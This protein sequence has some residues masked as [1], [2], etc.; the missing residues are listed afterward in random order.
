[1][2]ILD[3]IDLS[4]LA[5]K[6]ILDQVDLNNL[7][8]P[9]E[10]RPARPDASGASNLIKL[11]P[12]K[13]EKAEKGLP[14]P[15]T[16]K[17]PMNRLGFG[18]IP[19]FTDF[20]N[21]MSFSAAEG[22]TG[23]A[24]TF[25]RHQAPASGY[26]AEA[27][28][29]SARK[30]RI[31]KT[32][33]DVSPVSGY[34]G[35]D[36][37]LLRQPGVNEEYG[38]EKA[39]E[40]KK[41]LND[42]A[43]ESLKIAQEYQAQGAKYSE[44]FI[45][46]LDEIDWTSP[47]DMVQY[48]GYAAGQAAVQIPLN[49]AT[50]GAA[51][52]IQEIGEIYLS[53]VE[54]IATEMSKKLGREVTMEEIIQNGLDKPGVA[55]AYGVL[56]GSLE[57][58]GAGKVINKIQKSALASDLRKRAL[59][60]LVTGAWEGGTEGA[61][62]LIEQ[63]GTQAASGGSP[64]DTKINWKDIVESSSQGTI[65]AGAP[66]IISHAIAQ[67][68]QGGA[69]AADTAESKTKPPAAPPQPSSP[70][71]EPKVVKE[72]VKP[73][74]TLKEKMSIVKKTE[75]AEKVGP[76]LT[77]DEAKV[78]ES[79]LEKRYQDNVPK[80]EKILT[81]TGKEK[82]KA[83][84][85]QASD[86]STQL[87]RETL[88]TKTGNVYTFNKKTGKLESRPGMTKKILEDTE[89]TGGA[90][91]ALDG[92]SPKTGFM[93]GR[94]P[95]KSKSIK[96]KL[97]AFQIEKF[98]ADNKELLVKKN[99]YVGVWFDGKKT[100]L[101]ISVNETNEAKATGMGKQFGQKA[102]Y[103]V[104][105]G[106]D[107]QTG[108]TGK[109]EKVALE[110]YSDADLSET[111]PAFHGTGFA[112]AEMKRKK[113]DPKNFVDRTYFYFNK[114]KPEQR[115]EGKK[116]FRTGK[117][118]KGDLY[119]IN[120]DFEGFK[121]RAKE[122]G[123]VGNDVLTM[124]EKWI[125]EA[126]YKGYYNTEQG[127][128]MGNAVAMFDKQSVA[129]D[130]SIRSKL[131]DAA[132]RAQKRIDERNKRT[133]ILVDPSNIADYAI[134][135]A[136]YI[137][138]GADTFAKWSNSMLDRY[139][140]EIK[141]YLRDIYPKALKAFKDKHK[142]LVIPNIKKAIAL[143]HA[144]ESGM[145]WYDATHDELVRIFGEDAEVFAKIVAA[146][147][148]NATPKA[149]VTKAIK[150]YSN[151]KMG[152]PIQETM[153]AIRDN[154]QR[155]RDGEE[156][157]GPKIRPFADA[158]M[159]DENAVVIDSWMW[160]IFGKGM[161]EDGKG[162]YKIK[163]AIDP[164][165]GKEAPVGAAGTD[166]QRQFII[167][168]IN[169]VSKRLKVTPR[170]VQAALW[171]GFKIKHNSVFGTEG[172]IESYLQD[173]FPKINGIR[174]HDQKTFAKAAELF[175]K[176]KEE[177]DY[178]VKLYTAVAK[179]WA[180]TTG[181]TVDDWFRTRIHSVTQDENI[182]TD[183]LMQQAA[184]AFYSKAARVI[185]EKMGS[186]MEAPS[187]IN[188]LLRY[189]VTKEEMEWSGLDQLTGTITKEQA[190]E[191]IETD[192]VRIEETTLYGEVTIAQAFKEL[193]KEDIVKLRKHIQNEIFGDLNLWSKEFA[194]SAEPLNDTADEDLYNNY[195]TFTR[196][197]IQQQELYL[198]DRAEYSNY[199]EK[200]P[201]EK[202][203]ELLLTLPSRDTRKTLEEQQKRAQIAVIDEK[204][205]ELEAAGYSIPW[206]AVQA[207]Q[208]VIL[209]DKRKDLQFDL[210]HLFDDEKSYQT[211]H[212]PQ[213]RPKNLLAHVRFN[214][215]TINGERTL[216][217]EEI[218]SDWHQQG[219]DE[220][221]DQSDKK[222]KEIELLT[223]YYKTQIKYDGDYDV[224]VNPDQRT[225]NYK[226]FYTGPNGY[227]AAFGKTKEDAL[228]NLA[229]H[230]AKR[231]VT[232]KFKDRETG[233]PDAPFKTS[234]QKL[235]LSRMMRWAAENGY[236]QIAWTTGKQQA[237]RYSLR[238]QVDHIK[239]SV[240]QIPIGRGNMAVRHLIN[241]KTKDGRDIQMRVTADGIVE[242]GPNEF[243]G[244]HIKNVVGKEIAKEIMSTGS[245]GQLTPEENEQYKAL[246]A[247]EKQLRSEWEKVRDL[248]LKPGPSDAKRKAFAITDK[249]Q[250]NEDA[251][252]RLVGIT[253]T[254][255]EEGLEIGGQG[256]LY[257]YDEQLVNI[258]DKL[259]KKYGTKS[260]MGTLTYNDEPI[261]TMKM[262][263]EMR[264]DL[265]IDGVPLF[266]DAQGAVR[267]TADGRAIIHAFEGKS[268]VSTA[269]HELAHI[270][271]KE[272]TREESDTILASIDKRVKDNRSW[273]KIREEH[274]ARAFE[275]YLRTGNAPNPEL[276]T[277]FE[278]FKAWLSDIY[279]VVAGSAI[280]VKMTKELKAYFDKVLNVESAVPGKTEMGGN[281]NTYEE[282]PSVDSQAFKKWFGDSKV[283]DENGAP[284]VVY[285]GTL[286]EPFNVF[287][288]KDSGTKLGSLG[289]YFTTDTSV[290]DFY[291]GASD[292]LFDDIEGGSVYPVYLSIKKPLTIT[293]KEY[294]NVVIGDDKNRNNF[295][296]NI[297]SR[298]EKGNYDGIKIEGDYEATSLT[299]LDYDQ[300]VALEPTQIKS[301]TGNRGTYDS[302]NPN[303]L[304]QK[305]YDDATTPEKLS[306][307]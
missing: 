70:K 126:G 137:S 127:A 247:E 178:I 160:R 151:Y 87:M 272:M 179:T 150:E 152:R 228:D 161:E 141:P 146:T 18:G 165:T 121:D 120:N 154:L 90:S 95:E 293:A 173:A 7:D 307:T 305:V 216:F 249:I 278:K 248:A 280:D 214:E 183:A 175:T 102:I 105:T 168:Y 232:A 21:N 174:V 266:Q 235:A 304:F 300:Y 22:F 78:L 135:G 191:K 253:K 176:D 44:G 181:N 114:T 269:I 234:W 167:E 34:P 208:L 283:V 124:T 119:D 9:G 193:S 75:H 198:Q 133:N 301:A 24:E 61:Q 53:S 271:R 254:I 65:G 296:K 147:S 237:A 255:K 85:E 47:Y 51:G 287:N 17:R 116:R 262:P 56:A 207:E 130:T 2:S 6:S 186:K 284:L 171:F 242:Q 37:G 12:P 118:S 64:L 257:A 212:F 112:G 162:D 125:K 1:M 192:G 131:E 69:P 240:G 188:F 101:D 91:V 107:V 210:R 306:N 252:D 84:Q 67:I 292:S 221:Y 289:S 35:F 43:V 297:K 241:I 80:Q 157:K 195:P 219:R 30:Q 32:G 251:Q 236:D 16:D 94:Y 153:A 282:A 285:H 201:R 89:K 3:E 46:S 136:V 258:A 31:E 96:G 215:R 45:N 40:L 82:E 279:K 233:V 108:G 200:G 302:A 260:E 23:S 109:P 129:R 225:G 92:T 244:K 187:F 100:D 25:A 239:I 4:D 295:I 132:S 197:F 76:T 26:A 172:T 52:Y 265:M 290:A 59:S 205:K 276:Q 5:P 60:I 88:G 229:Y 155:I 202:Y 227:L 39:E 243:Q 138:H 27:A 13:E 182:G 128:T 222:E 303:I 184:S 291:A 62:S 224:E 231:D 33:L 122:E 123:Y 163:Y 190:L 299:D 50:F 204:I 259:G 223:K 57:L 97:T 226:S 206:T 203:R 166:G 74:A 55:I 281:P 103:N 145:E 275:R 180:K 298:I 110:H 49:V 264:Q 220:G 270:F 115:F 143:F 106:E 11:N 79:Q 286:R 134:I 250:D 63:V 142:A 66:S 189:G 194:E 164:K 71:A 72:E 274:F 263:D 28:S 277:I 73:E 294:E 54:K 273:D 217:I 158:I 238:K 104:D 177:Q 211:E 36:M 77:D 245:K 139:G 144:G 156:I 218:Q 68:K 148:V 209:R 83:L 185:A 230:L 29:V 267:F 58:L 288:P 98:V 111:D 169:D 199:Q 48:I 268:N 149:N 86:N 99:H 159:G 196:E 140:P 8:A 19:F 14:S 41:D 81:L 20:I 113:N 38:P 10:Q 261:H 170:Q 42:S 246:K 93:I 213:N 117:V 15:V 256:M